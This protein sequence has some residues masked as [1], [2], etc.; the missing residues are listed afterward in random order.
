MK[1]GVHVAL[2]GPERSGRVE[3]RLIKRESSKVDLS[4]ERS[5][6]ASLLRLSRDSV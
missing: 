5:C 4:L 3:E 1:F 6:A 2:H